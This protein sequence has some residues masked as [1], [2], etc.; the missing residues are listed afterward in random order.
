MWYDTSDVEFNQCIDK[1]ITESEK[2]WKGN[3]ITH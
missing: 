2:Y 3:N 1:G